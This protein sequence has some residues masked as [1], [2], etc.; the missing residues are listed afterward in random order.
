MTET[1][2]QNCH[3]SQDHSYRKLFNGD[4]SY[5]QAEQLMTHYTRLPGF[6]VQVTITSSILT[7]ANAFTD[8]NTIKKVK[9]T[10]PWAHLNILLLLYL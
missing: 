7:I 6:N 10:G 5:T 8:T 3:F 4:Q 1:G 9:I 2:L